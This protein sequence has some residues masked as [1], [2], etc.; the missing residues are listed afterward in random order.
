M[1]FLISIAIV[2]EFPSRPV[3]CIPAFPLSEIYVDVFM[4]IPLG[5]IVDLNRGEWVLKLNK[6]L[7]GINKSS[8]NWFDPLKTGLE[9]IFYHQYQVDPYVFY[10]NE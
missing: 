5:M 7:Y 2:H 10:R 9:R 4:D 6:S 1:R 3:D 8:E